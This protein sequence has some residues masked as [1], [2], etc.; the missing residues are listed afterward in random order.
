MIQH[1]INHRVRRGEKSGN[2]LEPDLILEPL[3][4]LGLLAVGL[5]LLVAVRL[6][7]FEQ[8]L[9]RPALLAVVAVLADHLLVVAVPV[10]LRVPFD[11]GE[12]VLLGLQP[13]EDLGD[14]PLAVGRRQRPQRPLAVLQI[15]RLAEARAILPQPL[16]GRVL[17][18]RGLLGVD[19]LL[20][21][22]REDFEP[23][24]QLQGL[25]VRFARLAAGLVAGLVVSR[26][27][28]RL[29]LLFT[30]ADRHQ[31]A[32]RPNPPIRVVS[33]HQHGRLMVPEGERH[34]AGAIVLDDLRQGLQHPEQELAVEN[35]AR[36]FIIDPRHDIVDSRV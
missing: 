22:V 35:D 6:A 17:R 20:H 8:L 14:T 19:L 24:G 2:L 10:H 29:G 25:F 3:D 28:A 31:D 13:G 23:L 36:A 7:G 4:L 16:R 33:G 12:N 18:H 1:R 30:L 5:G 21:R 32:D 15:G 11:Q 27:P 26:Q 9:Q 34:L